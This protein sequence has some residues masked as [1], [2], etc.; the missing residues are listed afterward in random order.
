MIWALYFFI[1]T[2]KSW[3][4]NEPIL[5]PIR[6]FNLD[7]KIFK[8]DHLEILKNSFSHLSL[9]PQA[10]FGILVTQIVLYMDTHFMQKTASKKLF[11]VLRYKFLSAKNRKSQNF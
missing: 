5:G 8:C 2:L 6:L 10:I 3:L 4:Q 9:R 7:L 1:N 11:S